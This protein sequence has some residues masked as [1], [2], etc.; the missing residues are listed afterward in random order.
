MQVDPAVRIAGH[1]ADIVELDQL[2]DLK[3]PGG[4][5]DFGRS[6]L[7]REGNGG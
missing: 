2:F 5:Q 7:V 1:Y 4:S 6:S 3:T